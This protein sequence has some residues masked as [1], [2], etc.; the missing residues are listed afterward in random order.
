VQQQ[1]DALGADHVGYGHKALPG[2]K[3]SIVGA[4]PF[5]KVRPQQYLSRATVSMPDVIKAS[6]LYAQTENQQRC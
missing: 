5:S 2:T 6:L 1:L 3:V 4:R